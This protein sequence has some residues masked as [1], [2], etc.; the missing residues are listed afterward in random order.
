M[1]VLTSRRVKY[2]IGMENSCLVNITKHKMTRYI[3]RCVIRF[4][5][6]WACYR[7]MATKPE[8]GTMSILVVKMM[9][10]IKQFVSCWSF[11]LLRGRYH[12]AVL[13][14]VWGLVTRYKSESLTKTYNKNNAVYCMIRESQVNVHLAGICYLQVFQGRE[15]NY[16]LLKKINKIGRLSK[17]VS[18]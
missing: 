17:P 16:S 12:F 10:V 4:L 15:C 13:Q 5:V 1:N 18:F 8:I 14:V 6:Y 9:M 7:A 11:T 3:H 2:L